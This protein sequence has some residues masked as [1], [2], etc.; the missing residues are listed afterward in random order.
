MALAYAALI[1][2]ASLYP[3]TDWRDQG[4]APWSFV[5]APWPKYWTG[6]EFAINIAGYMPLGF[7]CAIAMLRAR[8]DLLRARHAITLA[9]LTGVAL[10]FAMETLQSY[11]PMR[12]PSNI[13]WG[14]NSLGALVGA[15]LAALLERFGAL[16]HWGRTRSNWFIPEARGVL[17]LLAL[18]P[19]ALLYPAAVSFGLGQVYE[20]LEAALADILI[21]TPFIEWLPMREFELEPLVPLEELICVMLGALAP[22]LLAYMVARTIG[23]RALLLP[24][25]LAGGVA[26]SVLSAIL[27]WGPDKAWAWLTPPTQLGIAAAFVAGGLLLAAPRRLCVGLALI[28]LTVNL[29]LLNQAPENAYFAQ[30]LATWEQGRFIRFHGLAQWLGWIWPFAVI[31]YLLVALTRDPRRAQPAPEQRTQRTQG[32]ADQ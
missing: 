30:T 27:S 4:I 12:I 21:G 7:L 19:G 18:W 5:T 6:F 11:L 16:T 3:F 23:R 1:I 31:G 9:T 24:I 8:P 32:T 10:S 25:V 14:F 29:G 13:D 17:V 2:Y 20:R 28:V 26:T 22:C 15:V